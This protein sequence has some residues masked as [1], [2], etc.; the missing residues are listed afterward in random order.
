MVLEKNAKNG[1]N[2]DELFVGDA[3]FDD[4]EVVRDFE[5]LSTAR[6]WRQHLDEAGIEAVMTSDWP[7]DRSSGRH[8]RSGSARKL[9]R[10]RGIPD[11]A[12]RA[13]LSDGGAHL[14]AQALLVRLV[15]D[16]DLECLRFGLE[17]LV[18]VGGVHDDR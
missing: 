13:G 11:R 9:E 2:R 15:D 10:R 18:D 6:A 7:L 5:D 4:W 14:L 1:A 16:R 3:R 12:R 8:R 17:V